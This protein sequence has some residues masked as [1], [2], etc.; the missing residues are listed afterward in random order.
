MIEIDLLK[1]GP[2]TRGGRSRKAPVGLRLQSIPLDGW[3]VGSCLTVLLSLGFAGHLLLSVSGQ[4]A[5]LDQALEAALSDSVQS[6]ARRHRAVALQARRDSIAARVALIQEMDALRYLWPRIM[7]EVANALPAEAW[8]T[9]LAQVPS[10]VERVRF[11]VEG[12]ARTNRALTRFWNGLE[13]SPFIRDVR[14]IASDHAMVRS[15]GDGVDNLYHFILEADQEDP[16]LELLVLVP[17]S[18]ARA[19]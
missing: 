15:G 5:G 19:P 18:P 14:L 13:S 10:D 7:D 8:L 2:G 12:M 11:R 17:L 9:R 6:S 4:A 16:P 1:G 3:V